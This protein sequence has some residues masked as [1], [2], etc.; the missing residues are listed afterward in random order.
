MTDNLRDED[1]QG[2]PLLDGARNQPDLK[3]YL[4][5]LRRRIWVLLTCFV[6]I[7]TLGLVRAFKSTPV[8]RGVA[9]V[10][11]EK[12]TPRLMKFEDV[13]QVAA[14][15][16]AYYRTQLELVRSRAVL[17]KALE[18]P[19][20]RELFEVKAEGAGR[21]SLW[22]EARRTFSALMGATPAPIPE[23]WE[24]LRAVVDAQFVR[25]TNLLQIMVESPDPKRAADVANAVARAF[26]R[27]HLERKQ[28][29]SNEA[30]RFLEKQQ[31][32]Q[33]EVL[34]KAEDA[35]Q[36]F[37]EQ[38]R[39]VSLDVTDKDNPVLARLSRLNAELT[40]VQLDR[41]RLAAQLEVIL[42]RTGMRGPTAR[43]AGSSEGASG[44][45]QEDSQKGLRSERPQDMPGAEAFLSLAGVGE[46]QNLNA[47]HEKLIAAEQDLAALGL[48]YG[49]DHPQFR[50]AQ[51]K[52]RRLRDM[53]N[54]GLSQAAEALS[55]RLDVLRR[56][57]RELRDQYAEQNQLALELAK[58]SLTFERLQNQVARA[59]KLFDVL[60]ERTR[61]VDLSADYAKTN[62]E[63]VETAEPPRFAVRPRKARMAVVSAILGLLV[64]TGLA[65][66]FEHL[67]ETIKTPED[68]ESRVGLAVLGYVP[69]IGSKGPQG[70]GFSR[71]C[72]LTLAEPM[73]SVTE[74]YRNIRTSLFFSAPAEEA[75]VLVV[76]S[77]GPGDG[78]TTTCANLAVVIAQSGKRVLLVDGDLRR[79][80]LHEA[81]G[82]DGSIGLTN[83]LVGQAT[84]EQAV[85]RPTHNGA[86]LENLHVLTAGPSPPNPAE[87]LGSEN[88]RKLLSEAREKYDRVILDSAPVLFV[89]DASILAGLSDGVI[90][91]VKAAKNTRNVAAR[92]V[93]QLKG[94]RARILGGVLNDVRLSRMGY[95]YSDYYYSGYYGH[96]RSYYAS[97][98]SG[99]K[100]HAKRTDGG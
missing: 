76:T 11:I 19:G 50:A 96:Y 41:I 40:K 59:R 89:A 10:L 98:P 73:S 51:A 23:P 43:A 6:V 21:P 26:E 56:Q 37:R 45:G 22:E 70:D 42:G 75:K 95:Y 93:D 82:L 16:Q 27:Y 28:Q 5:I 92:A 86:V 29:T 72:T 55:A 69:I 80:R 47:L 7:T 31:A 33:R 49:P 64:G 60:V 46:F 2:R 94:V 1:R 4:G 3:H 83:V 39:L 61:E 24:R 99:P 44:A 14:A 79:S 12:Q 88:M 97:R 36:R 48:L 54:Q 90:V 25:D 91:V 65:F 32:D 77:G 62:V 17:E 66:V 8:Y 20:I 100:Q 68:L 63:L 52:V 13:V 57:E 30:F 15:D 74:A 84:L 53:L 58:Q 85:Q 38:A 34:H 81:F 35:L 78:K 18:E 87:L 71:R 9:K 67:D